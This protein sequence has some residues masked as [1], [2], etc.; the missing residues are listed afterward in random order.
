M[1][2]ASL[3]MAAAG[4]DLAAHRDFAQKTER[5]RR[6]LNRELN[7]E[8]MRMSPKRATFE[9]APDY[10]RDSPRFVHQ[11]LP[12]DRVLAR[13]SASLGVLAGWAVLATL[14]AVAATRRLMQSI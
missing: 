7:T 13:E 3:S 14:F 9:V 4:N 1:A 6:H 12:I 5:Y 2:A 8:Y 11:F 10:W